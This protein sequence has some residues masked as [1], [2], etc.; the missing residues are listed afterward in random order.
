LVVAG[1]GVLL[2]VGS[3]C[4]QWFVFRRQGPRVKLRVRIGAVD[5]RAYPHRPLTE[6]WQRQLA[7]WI[8]QGLEPILGV[9]VANLGRS[10]ITVLGL[11]GIVDKGP[12]FGML[13]GVIGA[14]LP[15]RLDSH[16]DGT[17]FFPL[18]DVVALV[19]ELRRQGRQ[20]EEVR[21]VVDVGGGDE[22]L[23]EPIKV[24]ELVPEG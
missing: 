11:R 13:S 18:A 21:I 17:W 9:E 2:A 20:P 10:G 3:L 4:W 14:K 1:L 19:T 22:H 12:V 7:E 15:H 5:G 8:A 16:D 23:T 24:A 6:G